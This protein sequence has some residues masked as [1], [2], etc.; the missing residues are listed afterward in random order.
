KLAEARGDGL[1]E[2]Q[3]VDGLRETARVEDSDDRALTI[4]AGDHG[5]TEVD[6]GSLTLQLEA[7]AEAAVLG[8]PTLRDVELAKDLEARHQLAAGQRHRFVEAVEVEP[9]QHAVDAEADLHP[10]IH[11]FQMNIGGAPSDGHSQELTHHAG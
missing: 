10:A 3:G 6:G 9:L 11:G 8:S 7:C 1:S 4:V 2:T 5:D